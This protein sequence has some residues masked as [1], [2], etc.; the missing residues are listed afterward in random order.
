MD[1]TRGKRPDNIDGISFLP[2]LQKKGVQE[3]HPY[4]YWEFHTWG[5]F[6]T[7][8]KGKWKAIRKDVDKYPES[9]IELYDL[10][11]DISETNDLA[12][13]YPDVVKEMIEIMNE[14]HMPSEK[15]PFPALDG[16]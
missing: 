10:S 1:I 7:V 15:F 14:A 2:T 5:G 9:P 8:R 11:I 16:I 3:T 4:L 6:Q 13:Q 12:K